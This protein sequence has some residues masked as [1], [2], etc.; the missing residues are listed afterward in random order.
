MIKEDVERI[1]KVEELTGEK[2]E[3][4]VKV[5]VGENETEK[6]EAGKGREGRR[7]AKEY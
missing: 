6:N 5:S 4:R 2:E 7:T 3:T 1:K